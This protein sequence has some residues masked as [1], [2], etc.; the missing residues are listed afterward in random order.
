MAKIA[1]RKAPSRIRYE[2]SH[3]TVSGRVTL[4][5]YQ[6]L[7]A[8]KNAEHKSF[9][10]ILKIGLGLLEVKV[11]QEKEAR[12]QGYGKGYYNGYIKAADLYMVSFPCKV[13]GKMIIATDN[14]EKEAI[15]TYMLE[16]GWAHAE[17]CDR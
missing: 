8:V 10:D 1:K 4:E 14:P 11:S 2:Q 15:K 17:C 3:P 6:K 12:Q 9:T 16:H 13:C 7:Q 5:I